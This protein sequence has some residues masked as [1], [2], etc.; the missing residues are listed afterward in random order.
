[1][2]T[3]KDTKRNEDWIEEI[4]K[5]THFK[6]VEYMMGCS[7]CGQ[8]VKTRTDRS[9]LSVGDPEWHQHQCEVIK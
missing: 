7:S 1:M 5:I 4:P 9:L 3:E 8:V 6:K 2:T